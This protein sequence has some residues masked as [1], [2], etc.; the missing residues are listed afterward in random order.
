MLYGRLTPPPDPATD[1]VAFVHIRKTAGT[2]VAQAMLRGLGARPPLVTDWGSAERRER[3]LLRLH[4]A[5]RR[6]AINLGERAMAAVLTLAGREVPTAANQPF[7]AAH[8]RLLEAP[9]TPRRRLWITIVR[10][11][12]A[13][14]VSDWAWMRT[15]RDR[16][17]GD[18]REPALYDLALEDF[19]AAI[20]RRPEVYAHDY[21]CRQLAHGAPDADAA[22]R[23]VDETLWLA[24]DLPRLDGFMAKAGAA[25]GV[26]FPP[27]QRVRASGAP[28]AAPSEA[29]TARIGA[30]NPG[31]ARLVRHV[32]AAF[33]AL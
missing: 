2:A 8:M 32:G 29:L 33:D 6:G 3:G 22:R 12:A 19:V 11:P 4:G 24:A 21:Q 30:L 10:D 16:A 5:L 23:A 26:A 14:F 1:Q 7:F 28:G 15:K 17:R 9:A 25:L 27:L 31:D 13:R 18:C 20:E